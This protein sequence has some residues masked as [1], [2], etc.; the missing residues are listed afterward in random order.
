MKTYPTIVPQ[1]LIDACEQDESVC[2]RCYRIRKTS[3]MQTAPN[4][5]IVCPICIADGRGNDVH[6]F[7]RVQSPRNEEEYDLCTCGKMLWEHAQAG[8]SELPLRARKMWA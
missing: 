8:D 1:H 6:Q 4:K 5:D 7:Q 3:M 2:S